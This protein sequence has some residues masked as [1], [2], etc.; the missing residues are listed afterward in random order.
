MWV[1]RK[2]QSPAA[3]RDA[4]LEVIAFLIYRDPHKHVPHVV[5][6]AG[7]G[8][9]LPREPATGPGETHAA[10]DR[11]SSVTMRRF[12]SAPTTHKAFSSGIAGLLLLRVSYPVPCARA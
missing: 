4:V 5:Q 8:V 9:E 11:A 7:D 6:D 3:G 2:T 1:A 12:G 10:R